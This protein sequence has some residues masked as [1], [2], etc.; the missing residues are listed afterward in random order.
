HE[1]FI[2]DVTASATASGVAIEQLHPEYGMNQFE[3]SLAPLPPVAGERKMLV[4]TGTDTS[5]KRYRG[6]AGAH[7]VL[8][9]DSTDDDP[10]Q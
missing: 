8:P 9:G 6:Q 5:R 10:H 1:G 3:I 7:A 2:R 4:G